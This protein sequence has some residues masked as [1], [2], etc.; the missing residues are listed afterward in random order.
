M[1]APE[2]A[3]P[4]YDIIEAAEGLDESALPDKAYVPGAEG[5]HNDIPYAGGSTVFDSDGHQ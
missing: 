1:P 5:E 2:I 3:S 4:M